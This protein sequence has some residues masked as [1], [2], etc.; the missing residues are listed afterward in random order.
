MKFNII[1]AYYMLQ[2]LHIQFYYKYIGILPRTTYYIHI[3]Y[4][5]VH[6]KENYIT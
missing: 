2:M 3:S 1:S 6:L 5:Y 4:T